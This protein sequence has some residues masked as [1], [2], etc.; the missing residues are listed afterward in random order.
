MLQLYQYSCSYCR[1]FT[2]GKLLKN[3]LRTHFQKYQTKKIELS[4]NLNSSKKFKQNF[5]KNK[6]QKTQAYL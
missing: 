5:L 6:L 3:I 2:W 4:K 1:V